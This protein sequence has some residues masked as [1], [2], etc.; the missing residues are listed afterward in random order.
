MDIRIK[1]LIKRSPLASKIGYG[2][3]ERRATRRMKRYDA[4]PTRPNQILFATT[5]GRFNDSCRPMAEELH[6]LRPE[7]ELVWVYRDAAYLDELPAWLRP[8]A[9]ESAQY[10]RELATSGAWVFNFLIPQGTVKRRDQ[11][12]IQVWHG[13]KPFKKIA[14][15]AAAGSKLYR[16]RT[17]GRKFSENKL[18][19]WF[20]TGSDLFIDVWRR[21]VGYEG[22][23]LSTGLP[24]ND[25]LLKPEQADLAAI[26]KELG[27]SEDQKVLLY[28]PTFRDHKL[29]NGNI[30]TD[31]DLNRVLSFLE[32]KYPGSWVCLKRAHGGKSISLA[33]TDDSRGI[34]DVTTYRDMT[35]L[36]LVSDVL[37]T[38]YS[39][40]AGD[41]AYLNRPVL[42][43][44]DDLQV[45]TTL[46]RGLIFDIHKTPFYRA[47]TMEE[48]GNLI[49]GLEPEAVRENCRQI[50]ELY[51]ST[52]TDHSTRDV[53][54]LILN[55]L[56]AL[57]HG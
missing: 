14:N 37:L 55:H 39:S 52:Q 46:D 18:C 44:Q 7:L 54:Q 10:Y 1:H 45:Y 4:L 40:C 35:D 22:K 25:I 28:A 26:R 15:E 13:D 11:L 49:R 29:D 8:V 2:L 31:I 32:E 48:L 21:S 38:D 57:G 12:Y 50:L 51:R 53:S 20:L 19:D 43:Y 47:E 41:F 9:F 42:L 24:R 36:M 27:L 3:R 30:G 16:K 17:K 5:E 23:V 6:R 33:N 34:L 56:D